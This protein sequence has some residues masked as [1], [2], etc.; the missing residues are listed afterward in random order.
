MASCIACRSNDIVPLLNFGKHALCNRYLGK[1]AD[2]EDS[3]PFALSQCAACALIQFANPIP[4]SELKAPYDW[5]SYNEQEGHLDDLVQKVLALPGVTDSSSVGAISYKDDTTLARLQKAG[6]AGWRLDLRED[7]NVSDP[8]SGL[9]TIQNALTPQTADTVAL[10]RQQV[11]VLIVRHILE[12]A[13][14]PRSF[15]DSLNRLIKPGGYL[16]FEVPDCA[17]ALTRKD[18]SMPWEEHISYFTPFTFQNT[19]RLLGFSIVDYKCYLYSN[20]NSLIAICRPGHEDLTI[21]QNSLKVE[22]GVAEKYSAA[23][24]AY[25]SSVRAE[26][27]NFR[28]KEGKIAIFGAGHLSCFW[29]NALAV[30]NLIEFVV[31]DHPKKKGMF[32]PGSHLPIKGSDSLIN[33]GIKLCL[34]SLSPES[35]AKVVQKNIHFTQNG[36]HF[37]TIFPGKSNSVTNHGNVSA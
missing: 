30:G 14:D 4:P 10:H 6:L 31:D 11:D 25:Q 33:E 1:P 15:A 18:Y 3:F 36:G 23:F 2:S 27:E 21:D 5:I 20:E 22:R 28:S 24:S 7:L 35:E 9:E 13:H 37:R 8:L 17:P 26:L 12:H 34:L 19:L 16:V 29:I 32:M